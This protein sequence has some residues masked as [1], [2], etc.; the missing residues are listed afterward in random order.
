MHSVNLKFV[1]IQM[2]TA[3]C[4]ILKMTELKLNAT[5]YEL[6]CT[7]VKPFGHIM[8]ASVKTLLTREKLEYW[9]IFFVF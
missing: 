4:I 2:F 5:E 7:L 3:D 6:I 8:L 9:R 1:V